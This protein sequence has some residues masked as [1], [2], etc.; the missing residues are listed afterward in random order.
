MIPMTAEELVEEA[1]ASSRPVPELRSVVLRLNSQG[2]TKD[3]ILDRLEQTRTKL[4]A[5][6]R[7]KD[8]EALM[9]V[10]DFLTGW[11]S[12]HM[13]L[14]LKAPLPMPEMAP[15]SSSHSR[16]SPST[17]DKQGLD[18]WLNRPYVSEERRGAL[19]QA[20]VVI[21]PWES[22]GTYKQPVFPNG[23]G[24]L[25]DFL[26]E[27]SEFRVEVPV[28]EAD[29]H[30]LALH[31]AS[32]DLGQFLVSAKALPRFVG[33]LTEFI[34]Y[35]WPGASLRGPKD[36]IAVAISVAEVGKGLTFSYSGSLDGLI[37]SLRALPTRVKA[38]GN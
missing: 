32:V 22:F 34:N 36:N 19:R 37:E 31:A 8:E 29:Y 30:E 21:L 16:L 20:D 35:R 2:L 3:L 15:D 23:T 13:K 14:R 27:P 26:T 25:F 28:E 4:R 6:G 11:C 18:Y 38:N 1:L 10:M 12:P 24:E 9:D 7:E 17:A 5:A 33:Q